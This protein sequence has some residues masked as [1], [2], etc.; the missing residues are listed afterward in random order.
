MGKGDKKTRRGKIVIGTSG[1]R[2][3]RKKKQTSR[4]SVKNPEP[5]K[6]AAIVETPV[7]AVK[8]PIKKSPKKITES[9]P[10]TAEK[11]KTVRSRKKTTESPETPEKQVEG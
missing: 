4:K 2:R 8:E 3:A 5:V 11:P 6:V 9:T 1:V 7:E 10:P